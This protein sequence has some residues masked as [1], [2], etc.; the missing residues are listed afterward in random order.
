MIFILSVHAQDPQ[1]SV[2]NECT[3]GGIGMQCNGL[4]DTTTCAENEVAKI[5]ASTEQGWQCMPACESVNGVGASCALG[6]ICQT[7]VNEG[8]QYCQ[9]VPFRMDLNL[10]D[11]CIKYWVEGRQPTLS[12]NSCS[13]EN[14]L[15]HLLDQNQDNE[16]DLF[17]LDLCILS[18]LEQPSTGAGLTPCDPQSD[19]CGVG[20]FCDINRADL[21]RGIKGVCARECG[22][23]MSREPG[24][25]TLDRECSGH[26]KACDYVE[27][28]CESIPL[29]EIEKSTCQVDRDCI[30]GS[31]C[32][33]G[34][35]APLCYRSVDCPNSEWYCTENNRCRVLP[36]PNMS[37]E[38]FIFDPSNYAIRFTRKDLSLDAIQTTNSAPLAIMD[39]ISRQQ[40][41]GNSAINFGYRARVSY[42][43]KE[44]L[45]CLNS[46]KKCDVDVLDGETAATCQARRADCIIDPEESWI[47]LT[48][49]F[50]MVN[51]AQNPK[52]E[53]QLDEA[54]VESL[55]PGK[56]TAD[57][58]V[59]Y[60]NGS[61]DTLRVTYI[62]KTV[63]G[64]Y[65]GSFSV[66]YEV[67]GKEYPLFGIVPMNIS[68]SI[69]VDESQTIDWATL[70]TTAGES[71]SDIN[72]IAS[73]QL[74]H[75]KLHGDYSL[76]FANP[77]TLLSDSNT[78]KT[79][80][81]DIDLQGIFYP[82]RGVIRLLGLIN[83]PANI[84]NL[85]ST[86][87]IQV[88]NY[89]GS[90]ITRKV[91]FFGRMNDKSAGIFGYYKESIRGLTA[92]EFTLSGLFNFNQTVADSTPIVSTISTPINSNDQT[93][94]Q[95]RQIATIEVKNQAILNCHP[96]LYEYF[97][98]FGNE[99]G[100]SFQSY[101]NSASVLFPHLIQFSDLIG[102]AL[103]ALGND[104]SLDQQE[105]LTI[106]D[107]LRGRIQICDED[108]KECNQDDDC[109]EDYLCNRPNSNQTG[110]CIAAPKK[111]LIFSGRYCLSDTQCNANEY[112]DTDQK[113]CL[114]AQLN[115]SGNLGSCTDDSDCWITC[116]SSEANCV[117]AY[118]C[119]EHSAKLHYTTYGK[120]ASGSVVTLNSS[121]FSTGHD[122]CNP[123]TSFYTCHVFELLDLIQLNSGE[124]ILDPT[125][126][127]SIN[128]LSSTLTN[129][130]DETEAR[131]YTTSIGSRLNNGFSASTYTANL[132]QQALNYGCD[133]P[134]AATEAALLASAAAG[135]GLI[136][137]I[138]LPGIGS[139]IGAAIAYAAVRADWANGGCERYCESTARS[140]VESEVVA[141]TQTPV[142]IDAVSHCMYEGA[143]FECRSLDHFAEIN[144]DRRIMLD[145]IDRIFRRVKKNESNNEP[146]SCTTTADCNSGNELS[147]T[148]EIAYET[149]APFS[150]ISNT[151]YCTQ[152]IS[153][154][155]AVQVASHLDPL[156]ADRSAL[157]VDQGGIEF[158]KT[159]CVNH[160]YFGSQL[161]ADFDEFAFNDYQGYTGEDKTLCVSRKD[162]TCGMNIMQYALLKEWVSF[163]HMSDSTREKP[164]FCDET[165]DLNA[166]LSTT[167]I[168]ESSTFTTN[169]SPSHEQSI[170][171]V[172]QEHNRFWMHLIQGLKFTADSE[173][174]DAFMTLYRNQVNPFAAGAALAYKG[175]KQAA[176]IKLYDEIM[177]VVSKPSMRATYQLWDMSH[178][179]QRGN[180]LLKLL[181]TVA[182]DR[183][184][185]IATMVDLDRR[186][187]LV[188]DLAR[189][190]D[191]VQ[192]M[193]QLDY[194]FQVYLLYLQIN[195]QADSPDEILYD[196]ASGAYLKKAQQVL[197]QVNVSRNALGLID[198]QVYFENSASLGNIIQKNW[199]Y[200]RAILIDGDE[201]LLDRAEE[202]LNQAVGELKNSLADM[203]ALE[204]TIYD[205]RRKTINYVN[206]Q[207]GPP[208]TE[209]VGL[210]EGIDKLDDMNGD[211]SLDY[212]DYLLE[213]YNDD[214]LTQHLIAC[215]LNGS[216][217]ACE[218]LAIQSGTN[219]TTS[220]QFNCN[221]S[222][223]VEE[224][225]DA[226][227]N[228]WGSSEKACDN[229][230]GQLTT[231][232]SQ[233]IGKDCPDDSGEVDLC[234]CPD[235]TS[236][237][238]GICFQ[239]ANPQNAPARCDLN[240]YQEYAV[241]LGGKRRICSGGAMGN[242]IQEKRLLEFQ[243]NQVI[244]RVENILRNMVGPNG[245]GKKLWRT[246]IAAGIGPDSS[247]LVLGEYCESP[248]NA[249][250]I[251]TNLHRYLKIAHN[252]IIEG[253]NNK[254]AE[255]MIKELPEGAKCNII[256]GLAV[257]TD[258]PGGIASTVIEGSLYAGTITADLVASGIYQVGTAIHDTVK[259][260][261]ANNVEQQGIRE[262][263]QIKIREVDALVVEF[264][265]LTLQIFNMNVQIEDLKYQIKSKF[266][267]YQD[268]IN[269][270]IDHL[271]GRESGNVL[272]GRKLVIESDSDY[273][274]VLNYSYRMLM[275]FIHEYNLPQAEADVLKGQ[276]FRSIT[277]NDI[278][279]FISTLNRYA[280]EYCGR[281]SIDCDTENNIEML[282]V[283][284]RTL[285]RPDLQDIV[286]ART[287]QVLTAGQQF[288]NI[289]TQPPY[290]KQRI[291]NNLPADFIE[292][293]FV[294]P[295]YMKEN[296]PQG[297]QWMINPF[298]CNHF[299]ATARTISD[300]GNVALNVIGQNLG[301]GEKQLD[302]EW[303]RGS[304]D[305]LKACSSVVETRELGLLP[306]E[307]YPIRTYT[308]GYAPQSL[309][310]Q[311]ENPPSYVTR[312]GFVP[313][314]LNELE[315]SGNFPRGNDC[316]R[317]FA[318]GR[319]LSASDW[320]IRMP[321]RIDGAATDNTWVMGSGLRSEDKPII[322]DIIL[323]FRY[324]S[325]PTDNN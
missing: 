303:I 17:D 98:D 297:P 131:C 160:S 139:L 67:D 37:E 315:E 185:A 109:G 153:S 210:I 158:K 208:A 168:E 290:M 318:R 88:N 229:V 135:G 34:Q 38:D 249:F 49:P 234:T 319:S 20:S 26:L 280:L 23:V 184:E 45:K 309:E 301:E 65:T 253:L 233:I 316:W 35:C 12:Q 2:D 46:F 295:L 143:D 13:L 105:Y 314:C 16:F 104:Q 283:S 132:T 193:V 230:K 265:T 224:G 36:S 100:S 25:N 232:A 235:G 87:P 8:P 51:A 127:G 136:G 57:V 117:N 211:G 273:R 298:E 43:L 157:G 302:F 183:L 7:N 133:N 50:G 113:V 148:C 246:C 271:I 19:S 173:L 261:N 180:D 260:L 84:I 204:Q 231:A 299:L 69:Y 163:S 245:F 197:Q 101:L 134:T 85:D 294:L 123:Q 209:I 22:L 228:S 324:V 279:Q 146:I 93:E 115:T 278:H 255:S 33:L 188:D 81:H 169:N 40:V 29:E 137:S 92:T 205:S 236:D 202:D 238:N 5:C 21:T 126:S 4:T 266:G 11:Q 192:N 207:C 267:L 203:D 71:S 95:I 56:Y 48:S 171:L 151:K 121:D 274:D 47:L 252:L 66:Y 167:E 1:L 293:S 90:N 106:Y 60:D 189:K 191:I 103:S 64:K 292:F 305:H 304:S 311:S 30:S 289:I 142:T 161:T 268:D 306:E 310:A 179:L 194:I 10:L 138:L 286:D 239:P 241:S 140:L 70:L 114:R 170:N 222:S 270:V 118:S 62:K 73:G 276:L 165:L 79:N 112:C 281:E 141:V 28:R 110:I 174:S 82:E 256:A 41:I 198:N 269:F 128:S 74:V 83:I 258:C 15:N 159:V 94:A 107:Y 313:A 58:E 242:L 282:R 196:N 177:A 80:N 182:N 86:D 223:T 6:E 291:V 152:K 172:S 254:W 240:R 54:V 213:K 72:D 14:N 150:R 284:L 147:Y 75:A 275:A 206:E 63:S 186:I 145:Y 237:R 285:L 175:E 89:F 220:F 125:R 300:S 130:L 277:L 263:L 59:I 215:K 322:E 221:G 321:I 200:Y 227:V 39:L 31:Y 27:G 250:S 264:Q 288:H 187:F 317:F 181:K 111:T 96:D 199:Q 259:E 247:S 296:G 61:T 91:E 97:L 212:C 76:S 243:R 308:I 251:L 248:R 149:E 325:R 217:E 195:W 124:T 257:G 119:T 18:F 144:G 155:R 3:F 262:E 24:G 53:V 166:C 216:D 272:L 201:A 122:I 156:L 323:Y 287:G 162:A 116:D 77:A 102:E 176:A 52:F 108:R 225:G 99:D 219:T 68:M 244:F 32:F 226:S 320:K 9:A 120:D 307:I 190:N 312:S 214:E 178:Y 218:A 42:N 129:L 154:F 164:L 55:T 78:N 44:D